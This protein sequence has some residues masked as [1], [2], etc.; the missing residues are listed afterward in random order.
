MWEFLRPFVQAYDVSVFTMP[1]FVPPDL[2]GPRIEFIPPAIDPLSPKNQAIPKYIW[3]KAVREFGIDLSRPLI[4]QVARFDPWKDPKGVIEVYRL[5]KVRIPELQLALIG[6]MAE[7]D[8]EGWEIYNTICHEQ[9][10]DPDLYIL[11]S[12][13]TGIGAREVNCFQRVADVVIQKSIRE[14]FG[15]VVSE[16]L[17]KGTPVVAGS[18]GGIP[19]QMQD[20]IGGFLVNTI[21]DC[22]DKVAHLLTHPSEAESI[23]RSG[24]E[25]VHDNFLIPRLLLDELKL[26]EST[27]AP[28]ITRNEDGAKNVSSARNEN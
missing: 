10:N 27:L 21:E 24:W 26:L 16:A 15:L 1:E 14:G 6:A 13:L 12:N 23:A 2:Q 9:D 4:I 7:D 3:G 25:R 28:T 22:A 19:L 20:G 8:P 18:T 17:W 11:I 5:V